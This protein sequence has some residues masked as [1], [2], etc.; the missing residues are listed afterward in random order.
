[1][2]GRRLWM[3]AAACLCLVRVSAG[4]P[5]T[6]AEVERLLAK[7]VTAEFP[8]TALRSIIDQ[9]SKMTGAPIEFDKETLERRGVRPDANIR[10][11]LSNVRL[12]RALNLVLEQVKLDYAVK[13]GAVWITSPENAARIREEAR[14]REVPREEP[15]PQPLPRWYREPAWMPRM[16]GQ[17]EKHVTAEF[18]ETTFASAAEF[19][20][21]TLKVNLVVDDAALKKQGGAADRTIRLRMRDVRGASLV[22]MVARLFGLDVILR[23]GV[24]FLGDLE[25]AAPEDREHTAGWDRWR[26][27][28]AERTWMPVLRR[29]LAVAVVVPNPK[30]M[31]LEEALALLAE[32]TDLDLALD[33]RTGLAA[34]RVTPDFKNV[35]AYDALLT[36]ETRVGAVAVVA[37]ETILFTGKEVAAA[38]EKRGIGKALRSV[39]KPRAFLARLPRPTPSA[40][41]TTSPTPRAPTTVPATQ[42]GQPALEKQ[43]QQWLAM[44]RM[45][46]ANGRIDLCTKY[47]Q[48]VLEK[49]PKGSTFEQ[50]ARA[51]LQKCKEE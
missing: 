30:E 44:A 17:L 16:R 38:L 23:D 15:A 48:K 42:P 6:D 18:T 34:R 20:R 3:G 27:A 2:S 50:Q 43:L 33:R 24:V 22:S 7:P 1:M 14:H 35:T 13:D 41:P 26:A 49:A 8:G 47:C 37:D 11:K 32:E 29:R 36:L 31:P 51:L 25:A 12:S 21:D 45:G 40:V 9:L 10:I 39:P 4:A 19:I 28:D 46:L 5:M